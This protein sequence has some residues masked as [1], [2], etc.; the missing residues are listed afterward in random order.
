MG[1]G[2]ENLE[3][4]YAHIG[5]KNIRWRKMTATT[6]FYRKNMNKLP[7][8]HYKMETVFRTK[9]IVGNARHNDAK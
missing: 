6:R 7:K 3:P 1:S 5:F 4:K 2:A 9:Q 8:I